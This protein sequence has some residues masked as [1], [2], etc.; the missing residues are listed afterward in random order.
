MRL[1][2]RLG[3]LLLATLAL[4]RTAS[5]ECT[6]TPRSCT[7]PNPMAPPGCV[8][9]V[10][11]GPGGTQVQYRYLSQQSAPDTACLL[12]Q[13]VRLPCNPAPPACTTTTTS[14]R[15]T[16]ATLTRATTTAQAPASTQAQR[17][18]SRQE[19]DSVIIVLTGKRE[20]G[21]G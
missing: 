12:V 8:C 11:C 6:Y 10:A 3:A 13:M 2:L 18:V 20:G 19:D 14:P 21:R 15:R 7:R 16:S 4:A 9:S 1:R 5:A 17:A